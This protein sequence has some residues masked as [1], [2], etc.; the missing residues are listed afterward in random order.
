EKWGE[1]VHAIIVPA[2]GAELSER[3]VIDHC[4]NLIAHYKCPASVEMRSEP[5]P[6]SG[7]GKVLKRDLRAPF[8]EGCERQVS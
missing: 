2:P 7:A 4:R 6:L 5:L 3:Q 1:A 8:W